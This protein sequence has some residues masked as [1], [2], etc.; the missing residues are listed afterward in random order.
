MN[1]NTTIADQQKSAINHYLNNHPQ[2]SDGI[3]FIDL[4]KLSK[5]EEFL[6]SYSIDDYDRNELQSVL[7]NGSKYGVMFIDS[8]SVAIHNI[9]KKEL[10]T[11]SNL[12][13][14]EFNPAYKSVAK[15]MAQ[16]A[17]NAPDTTINLGDSTA[18]DPNTFEDA[19]L[20]F[21][22]GEKPLNAIDKSDKA[23]SEN[24]DNSASSG[25]NSNAQKE[26]K[27][28]GYITRKSF[29]MNKINKT[30]NMNNNEQNNQLF[31]QVEQTFTTNPLAAQW[32]VQ[33][34]KATSESLDNLYTEWGI[35]H[36]N[37]ESK[38]LG[39]IARK[40]TSDQISE[41]S[42]LYEKAHDMNGVNS[43]LPKEIEQKIRDESKFDQNNDPIVKEAQ[44]LFTTNSKNAK[45]YFQRTK[46]N[47]EEINNDSFWLLV[48]G[49]KEQYV[50]REKLSK[51]EKQLQL[52]DKQV[53]ELE[54]LYQT[55][56]DHDYNDSNSKYG[57]NSKFTKETINQIFQLSKQQNKEVEKAID[58]LPKIRRQSFLVKKDSLHT[59]ND[60]KVLSKAD[61]QLNRVYAR[62]FLKANHFELT[63]KN[64]QQ[65]SQNIAQNRA[66]NKKQNR[67]SSVEAAYKI[68]KEKLSDPS[69]RSNYQK[70]SKK[71]SKSAPINP[72]LLDQNLDL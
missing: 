14:Y 39:K 62:K 51:L 59:Q 47:K 43:L 72:T 33:N 19:F 23:H 66:N 67:D 3:K 25:T 12:K 63:K 48:E 69:T 28:L 18:F 60:E 40:L 2:L 54:K 4:E 58:Q 6:T 52:S 17:P 46:A 7:K 9:S 61:E 36:A 41:F 15:E 57:K 34:K 24:I 30:P 64:I 55:T 71:Q 13:D 10:N 42:Q 37:K 45:W 8:D 53:S 16:L 49:K 26:G 1:K 50:E 5:N 21:D 27:I 32:W 65:V 31:K 11:L 56:I 68:E 35:K 70:S 44:K 20:S 38:K 22:K 29:K